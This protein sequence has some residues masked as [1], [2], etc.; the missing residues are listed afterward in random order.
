MRFRTKALAL[1]LGSIALVHTPFS[2]PASTP[3]W[4]AQNERGI[5]L[6]R[7]GRYGAAHREFARIQAADPDAVVGLNNAANVY[8]LEGRFDRAFDLYMRALESD[9]LNGGVQLNIG[10][11]HHLVGDPAASRTW[12]RRGLLRIDDPRR[13]YY[14]LG[15]TGSTS[16]R[17]ASDA[18]RGNSNEI[19]SLLT[20]ALRELP[21]QSGPEDEVTASADS[22]D[23]SDTRTKRRVSTRTGG[24]R[25]SEVARTD[26]IRLY[27]AGLEED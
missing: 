9:P 14:L 12:L 4:Q 11:A 21:D 13:A 3:T 22:V 26:T 6:A 23:T 18:E 27:W 20:A 17:R 2:A 5:T 16:P 7:E 8:L 24:T 19:E 1:A 15:L 10:I 25:A